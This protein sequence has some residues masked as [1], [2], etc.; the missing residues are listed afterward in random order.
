MSP[1]ENRLQAEDFRRIGMSSFLVD[2]AAG[3]AAL[4]KLTEISA[5]VERSSESSRIR[6]LEVFRTSI[7]GKEVLF[8][9]FETIE[10][11][12]EKA[13]EVLYSSSPIWEELEASI[14]PSSTFTL[15]G[16]KW[17]RAEFINVI[18][19]DSELHRKKVQRLGL[20]S[21]LVPDK[22]LSYRTVHQT[23]WPGVIDQMMRSNY[24]N[25]TTFLC[26]IE[27]RLLLFTYVEYIGYN[28]QSDDEVM[29]R[30]PVTQR[31]WAH[32]QPCIQAV[33]AGESAW[34][35]MVK[36]ES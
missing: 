5:N 29:A 35:E 22:E 23:N 15:G 14:E 27:K 18:A 26:E 36:I 24:R 20:V 31:W 30:D 11:D 3:K 25:W 6:C 7:S 32:T 4:E 10:L 12:Q 1:Y 2:G 13:L 34:L 16:S 9:Y 19:V 21:E 33:D 28:R 8:V 17:S